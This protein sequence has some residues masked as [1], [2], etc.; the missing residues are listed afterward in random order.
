MDINKMQ[1]LLDD[2]L[3]TKEFGTIYHPKIEFIKEC[4]EDGYSKLLF[5]FALTLDAFE[6]AEKYRS[7]IM[8]FDLFFQPIEFISGINLQDNLLTSLHFFFRVEP[9]V[10]M[11]NY[12]VWV[13]EKIIHR[14]NFDQLADVILHMCKAKKVEIEK[15]P[16]F[17]NER[18][19]DIYEKIMAGRKRKEEKNRVT[20]AMVINIVMNGGALCGYISPDVVKQMTYYQLVNRYEFLSGTESWDVNFKQALSFG[21]DGSKLDLT[22]WIAK[23]NL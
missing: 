4:G 23:I 18:Q 7:D 14:E 3:E 2:R 1:L 20:L 11:E 15:P 21:T 17:A 22:H 16:E 8:M 10:D 13:N 5:P 6:V 9:R 12:C 19:R